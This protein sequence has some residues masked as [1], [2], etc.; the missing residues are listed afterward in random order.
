[1]AAGPSPILRRVGAIVRMVVICVA[2]SWIALVTLFVVVGLPLS[3]VFIQSVTLTNGCPVPV[4]VTPLCGGAPASAR[5]LGLEWS[6]RFPIPVWRGARLP[7]APG[8]A[9]T[10]FY[11]MDDQT[12]DAFLVEDGTTAWVDP[13]PARA[14]RPPIGTPQPDP[15]FTLTP[16]NLLVPVP[17]ALLAKAAS[18]EANSTPAL[19]CLGCLGGVPVMALVLVAALRWRPLGRAS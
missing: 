14:S 3:A 13:A 5:P 1:M 16:T 2:A 15:A 12:L 19:G 7:L 9:V 11:D 6:R 18:A 10:I 8:E 17:A 4:K